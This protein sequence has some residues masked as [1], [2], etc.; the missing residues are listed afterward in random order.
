MEEF[1]R[2][3]QR[4][5]IRSEPQR[6]GDAM[7]AVAAPPEETAETP[8]PAHKSFW[9]RPL[10]IAI[11]VVILGVAAFLAISHLTASATHEAT[12]DAFLEAHVVSIAP[13]VSG[14]VGVV[15][16]LENQVV[17]NGQLLVEIDPRDFGAK[18]AQKQASLQSAEAN[19]KTYTASFELV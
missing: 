10:V 15:H 3:A 1:K 8:P 13:K 4:S 19:S 7:P 14:I 11:G 16:V 2:P 12:D 9:S 5:R 6:P 17:T 18:L